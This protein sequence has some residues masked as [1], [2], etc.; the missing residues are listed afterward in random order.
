M[1]Y[2]L[3]LSVLL[4]S[5]IV[6]EVAHGF[7]AY[8]RGDDT[9]KVMGRLTLNPI[10]HIDIFG[11]II[12]PLLLMIVHAPIFG[13]AKPVP[14]NSYKLNNPQTDMIW[15]SLAGCFANFL[16][17]IIAG[18]FMFLI[19]NFASADMSMFISLYSI[20]KIVLVINIILPLLN[21]IPIPPLD[22][23]RVFVYLLPRELAIKYMKIEPYGFLIIFAL[24]STGILWSII[25]PVA[26]FLISVLS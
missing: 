6:H 19:R 15:V 13:W 12:L 8:K 18:F 21:L 25:S 7:V 11:S 3:Q 16:L 24:L 1:E 23:S 9:A 26:Y 17:A 2:I 20:L 14:V 4:F 22:G 5:V 10:A